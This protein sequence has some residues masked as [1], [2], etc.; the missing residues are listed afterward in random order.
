MK[1]FPL[2]SEH[3]TLFFSQLPI[4]RN[5]GSFPFS[6]LLFSHLIPFFVTRIGILQFSV[7]DRLPFSN[8][9]GQASHVFIV[10]STITWTLRGRGY[11]PRQRQ[12]GVLCI[13]RLF[14]YFRALL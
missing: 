14:T 10:K 13:E 7:N 9:L 8:L 11:N 4:I 2:L 3:H 5:V 12:H 1:S 6:S